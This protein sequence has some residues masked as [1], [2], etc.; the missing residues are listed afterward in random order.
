MHM[1]DPLPARLVMLD[2]IQA[3]LTSLDM[4]SVVLVGHSYGTIIAAHLLRAATHPQS[5]MPFHDA[6]DSADD[7]DR[8][9]EPLALAK[10]I[11]SVLLVDPIP[12]LL[13]LPDVTYNFLY[14]KP[15]EANEWLLW[16]FSSRDADVSRLLGRYLWWQECILWRE[17]L[18]AESLPKLP[19]PESEHPNGKITQ[20]E[21]E[22]PIAHTRPDKIA[23]FLSGKDQIVHSSAVWKYLTREEETSDRWV[24]EDGQLEVLYAP[25][26]DHAA[27]F[28]SKVQRK[29]LLEVLERFVATS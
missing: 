20:Q 2:A 3:T 11:D 16:F 8:K 9:V 21:E 18:L 24:S 13:H 23:V 7:L 1:T 5:P 17:D 22:V 25:E 15:K 4:N 10:K 28:D 19:S 29:V 27:V 6:S 12:L 26:M 14:R